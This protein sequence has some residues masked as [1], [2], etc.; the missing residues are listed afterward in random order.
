MK[1]L[2]KYMLVGFLAG[3]AI[4]NLILINA[5]NTYTSA[6]IRAVIVIK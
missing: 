5:V 6:V 3:A 2:L 4:G 1:R